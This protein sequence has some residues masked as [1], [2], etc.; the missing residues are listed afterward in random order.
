MKGNRLGESS[1]YAEDLID[2]RELI[3][4]DEDELS[5]A[6]V[7]NQLAELVRT[8]PTPS[9]VALYG[10]WGSGKTGISNLLKSAVAGRDGMRYVR[11]DAFKYADVPLRRNFISAIARE[12][13]VTSSKYHDDLYS[14]K[15]STEIKVPATTVWRLLKY[16]A[17]L[18]LV[19]TS[20]LAL[21]V[22]IVSWIQEGD[23]GGN[24]K[25]L[26]FSTL[27]AGLLPA[28]LLAALI[29]LAS[30]TFSV[31]RAFVRPESDEQF[32]RLFRDLVKDSCAK[33]LIL[34]VDELDRCSANEVVATLDAVRTFLGVPGCVFVIAADQSV[35][36][37]ALSSSLRQETPIDEINPYYST[38]SGYLDKVFQYQVSLPPLLTQ[39]VSRYASVLVEG[40]GGVWREIDTNHVLSILIPTHVTSPRR[41]KHLLNTFVLTY[42]LAE[43]RFRAG[44][45]SEC[46]R[47]SAAEIARLVCLRVEFPL[48]ARHLEESPTLP[49]LVLQLYRDKHA[50]FTS[51]TSG[52]EIELARSYALESAAPARVIAAESGAVAASSE[53]DMAVT[54][55]DSSPAAAVGKAHNR[56]LLNYLSRTRQV[57]GPSR[58][59]IYLQSSGTVFG[60]D[61]DLARRI[62]RAA[63]DV[64]IAEFS[65]L[66]AALD[67]A[68]KQ[69]ALQLVALQVASGAGIVAPNCVRSLLL[70]LD[71]HPDAPVE[72]IVTSLIENICVLQDD[73]GDVLDGDTVEGAWKLAALEHGRGALSLRRRVVS[74]VA[75]SGET[76]DA[77]FLVCDILRSLEASPARMGEVLSSLLFSDHASTIVDK[78]YDRPDLELVR[79]LAMIRERVVVRVQE[80]WES[81]ESWRVEAEGRAAAVTGRTTASRARAVEEGGGTEPFDPSD[82]IAALG[83]AA[84][85]R[86]TPVQHETLRILLSIDSKRSRDAAAE[87]IQVSAPVEDEELASALLHSALRQE[88]SKLETWLRGVSVDSLGQEHIPLIES[89]LLSLWS[90]QPSIDATRAVLDSVVELLGEGEFRS[91]IDLSAKV[92]GDL[93]SGVLDSGEALERRRLLQHAYLFASVGFID[94]LMIADSVMLTLKETLSLVHPVVES[95]DALYSYVAVD[96]RVALEAASSRIE[97]ETVVGI[98]GQVVECPWLND[99]ARFDMVLVL[100]T[101]I[102]TTRDVTVES[103]PSAEKVAEMIAEYGN[104][105]FHGTLNWIKLVRPNSGALGLV[106]DE[107]RELENVP[108]E[109]ARAVNDTQAAW[110]PGERRAH[111]RRYVVQPGT[112]TLSDSMLKMVGLGSTE[113]S[114]VVEALAERY[115]KSTNNAQRQVVVDLWSRADLQHSSARKSLIETVV[116][117]LLSLNTGESRN[118]AAVELALAALAGPA[119]PL[120]HGVKGELLDR[121]EAAIVEDSKLAKKARDVLS[122]LGYSTMRTGF[123]GRKRAVVSQDT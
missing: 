35:L 12:L 44:L 40:R 100:A 58:S 77:D 87:L 1:V 6:G 74:A 122:L 55:V 117:G 66:F 21:V 63:E 108:V 121:I 57:S 98:L 8:V 70:L 81:H 61:G 97:D 91:E 67:E 64:D 49:N 90:R 75:D 89:I 28:S 93:E 119:R 103:L 84:R 94:D 113:D 59:L 13:G 7:V 115:S 96:G 34:F 101:G 31:D 20:V 19:I 46:P 29:T 53:E 102:G 114:F 111:L 112:A 52:R 76:I 56:Q 104:A 60:L 36:E 86:E 65:S 45:L 15:T 24:F 27:Q 62:E 33:R 69:A 50:K 78:L 116:Y 11:F 5:H 123:F 14:G 9:N 37:E 83:I 99:L 30:K 73:N 51:A 82:L 39:S 26:S 32:E 2:D 95:E 106:L 48:F 54:Q 25:S 42:R 107:L 23:F 22:A 120:P 118:A 3:S 47:T 4:L 43:E 68:S 71:E 110:S 16:F 17:L 10:P 72:R 92:R 105:A 38:G 18:L 88:T 85:E 41:V 109:L 80:A 79:V